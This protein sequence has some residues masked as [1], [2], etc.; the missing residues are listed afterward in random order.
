[1]KLQRLLS[2]SFLTLLC[3]VITKAQQPYG[4]CWHPDY[5]RTWTP[6]SDPNA[7]FNRSKVPLAK[8]V[9]EPELMKANKN[10]YYEGQVCDATILF[11]ICS[12]CPS[13]GANNFLGYQPTY[14]QYMDKLIYWAG[15]ASEGIII[16]PPAGSI[17]AAHQSGVKALGQIFFPPSYYGGKQ[18]W[19]RELL[20]Q[21][22]G[23]YIYARK[24]YEIAKYFGFDGWFINEETGG[25][26]NSEWEGF[27]KEFNQIADAAGDTQMEIQWYNASGYPNTQIL[28]THKNTSQFLEY[29]YVGDKRKYA[30]ELGI[31]EGE[32]FSKIY[33]GIQCVYSGLTG[34]GSQLRTAFPTTGHVGSVDLFCP[35]ERAWK[36]HVK[37]YLNDNSK[38]QGPTAYEAMQKV[39]N[40]EEQ[41]WVN[42]LGDPSQAV[43]E[44][45][46]GSWPGISGCILERTVISSMPFVSSMC[47]G[48][49]KHRFVEGVKKGT[50]DWY[51]SSVQSILPTWRWWIENKGDLKVSIDWDDAWNLGSSFK[52]AGTLSEGD[53]L[54]RLYKTQ[55]KVENG[56]VFRLVYK[57]PNNVKIE[58]KLST[59]SSI[60]PDETL[61]DPKLTE[62]N[63]WIIADYDL[64][65]L[66]GKT[67]YMIALNVKTDASINN[68]SVNLG[69]L[70][71]LPK[72]Y[73]PEIVKVT[74]FRTT[75]TLGDEEGDLRLTWDY[76]YNNHFDHFDIYTVTQDGTRTLVGQ[77]RGEG[78]Y[79]PTFKRAG[80]DTKIG[81]ELVPIMK[82]MVERSAEK[83]SVD[84]PAPKAPVVTFSLSKSYVKVGDKVTMTA[85]ATGSPT[86]FEWV[87]P[88]GLILAEG[89]S[90][91]KQTIEVVAKTAGR[92]TVT[93][94]ATNV[95]GTSETK[96]DALDVFENEDDLQMVTNVIKHKTVVDYSGSTN[97]S[98]IP[99]KIIDGIT[100]PYNTSDKW[101]NISSD[102][103]AIFDLQGPYRIYG[104]KIYDGNAGPE[105]GV[106]QIDQYQIQ[107]SSDMKNWT[108]VVNERG[109]EGITIKENYI[110]PVR[111]RYVK[112]IP[113]VN[114]TL[115]IWEFEVFGLSDN[116]MTM[117]VDKQY[118]INAGS[119]QNIVVNYNLNG[120]TRE[121]DFVCKVDA[122]NDN[123]SI[124]EITEDT[125]EGSFTIP[126]TASKIIGTTSLKIT[127][128]NG[129]AYIERMVQVTIDDA[130]QPNVLKGT[131]ATLRLYDADY[132]FEAEY[133]EQ[134]LSTLTDGEMRENACED[135]DHVSKH[136]DDV[137]AIFT[138]PSGQT[139]NLS[140]VVV[141]IP[142][143]N[144]EADDNG[145][146]GPAN[147]EVKIAMGNDLTR[148]TTVKTF[149]N[150]DKLPINTDG[151]IKLECILPEFM[152]VK[153]LAVI[154][155]MNALHYPLLSEVE[156]YEQLADAI[157]VISPVEISNWNAD[158]I[159]EEKDATAHATAALDTQGWC[160]YTKNV[161]EK[162][163]LSDESRK[164]VSKSGV[165]YQLADYT[166]NNAY[167]MKA[168]RGWQTLNFTTPVECEE[169]YVLLICANGDG[170]ISIQAVYE[171]DTQKMISVQPGDWFE[172]YYSSDAAVRGLG[173][174]KRGD[175]DDFVENQIDERY[176]FRLFDYTIETDK[177]KKV[178]SIDVYNSSWNG[179]I[180]TILAV[181]R[182]GKQVST[183]IRTIPNGKTEIK[184]VG[185]YNLNGIRLNAPVK[186]LNIIK[187][188]DGSTKKVLVQ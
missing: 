75:S 15:S 118:T 158:V 93:V 1:M 187:F 139:W 180:P 3:M 152:N 94:K 22:N 108:T 173:R 2:V 11:P 111:A 186:G 148:L 49:G 36:D 88:Q 185:I 132:S 60:T 10:Q 74:N 133:T 55:I 56:G 128:D 121:D 17:D 23:S 142:Y 161:Q 101:C 31:S 51:N 14:W 168:G 116:K 138:A 66:N 70:A 19:V 24:L 165:T 172:S 105:S 96:K 42:K 16:P 184:V 85:Q 127:I 46:Y 151:T 124:G 44:G 40:S 109:T 69:S 28:K 110:A 145:D 29:G 100:N 80:I 87:L 143:D 35:E 135:V 39:F 160:L 164:V 62:K 78:F 112:L 72:D 104:F 166:K 82:D 162:G 170:N 83:L 91:N 114:G 150:I 174:I 76:T 117:H 57:N 182:K 71:V 84:Y 79:V 65:S 106:D 41:M 157:P 169:L 53:H 141:T 129:G 86:S 130:T 153:Y 38:N 77:T 181:S 34:Y 154:C 63:G 73:A 103:W 175:A 134:E 177:T 21:E 155:N 120:D 188:S 167:R 37:E 25:G 178:K 144:N 67:I 140:K 6:E 48:N 125:K 179:C 68:F 7:K 20:T 64:N 122:S 159:V 163:A 12:M 43:D 47:V 98:E 32:T 115:R 95:V 156:A 90:L 58:A 176:Q 61:T 149:N 136:K 119:T 27:I 126:I 131:K 137:W 8:R 54:M 45:S 81:V 30:S 26:S 33:S 113:H 171:D 13:Q 102:N 123:V 92:K 50:Q 89:S 52:I 107:V 5:V 146:V 183:A 18:A 59:K 147:K 9:I 4:G 97:G 99:S